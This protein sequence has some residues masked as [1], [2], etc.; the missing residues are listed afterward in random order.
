M[1][2]NSRQKTRNLEYLCLNNL[3]DLV[4]IVDSSGRY[5]AIWGRLMQEFSMTPA[6]CVGRTLEEVLGDNAPAA[7]VEYQR[8]AIAG[9]T[10][11]YEVAERGTGGEEKW[12]QTR[13]TPI[14][15]TGDR[16]DY[17]LGVTRE[18]TLLHARERQLERTMNDI[19]RAM[20]RVVEAKDPFT[21]DHQEGV[22]RLSVLIATEMGFSD[23]EISEVR[24]AALLHDI[25]KLHI[26][27]EILSKPTALGPNEYAIVQTHAQQ[28]YDILADIDF[29]WPIA[30]IALQHHER[31]DGSGYP[32][33][34]VGEQILPAARVLAVADV[35]EAVASPRP[36]RAALGM[37]AGVE[38]IA[39]HPEAFDNSVSEACMRLWKS[40]K[41]TL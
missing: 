30:E 11:L 34:L 37:G 14:S 1:P 3:E 9:E 13:L 38:A 8:R 31:A 17:V 32:R 15:S 2:V 7:H 6:L 29:G 10:A 27:T 41:L 21:A 23:D 36:Y 20:G 35:L 33:G 18:T 24:T 26:P 22:A 12:F 19:V 25:G 28:G 5:V 16:V 40:G 4:F 39:S